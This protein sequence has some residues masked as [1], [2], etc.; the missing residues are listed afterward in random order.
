[1]ELN[2][3]NVGDKN[4]LR[5]YYNNFLG[6]TVSTINLDHISN[7]NYN[8]LKAVKIQELETNINSRNEPRAIPIFNSYLESKAGKAKETYSL[9]TNATVRCGHQL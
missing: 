1:M 6:H 7:N 8:S 2:I 3:Y 5:E 4:Y 9:Q